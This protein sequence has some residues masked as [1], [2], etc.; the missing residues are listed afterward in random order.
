M[1]AACVGD[2]DKCIWSDVVEERQKQY[3]W[4]FCGVGRYGF[5]HEYNGF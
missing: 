5:W 2:Y 4:R 1:K 3:Q